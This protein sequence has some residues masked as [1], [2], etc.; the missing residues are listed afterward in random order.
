MLPIA[1]RLSSLGEAEH[2]ARRIGIV[3]RGVA[4]PGAEGFEVALFQQKQPR[5]L[6]A[7]LQWNEALVAL[8]GRLKTAAPP[9]SP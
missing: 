4:R 1:T 5:A 6:P 8:D 7:A 3:A 9:S 2:A